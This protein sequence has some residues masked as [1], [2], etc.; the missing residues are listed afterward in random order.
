LSA[1][2][3][4]VGGGSVPR[5]YLRPLKHSHILYTK[6]VEGKSQ[7]SK[8]T[9]DH[10]PGWVLTQASDADRAWLQSVG[11]FAEAVEAS[12]LDKLPAEQQLVA[13]TILERQGKPVPVEAQADIAALAERF[14]QANAGMWMAARAIAEH[15]AHD[16]AL[17]DEAAPAASGVVV[18][19]VSQ[20]DQA[21]VFRAEPSLLGGLFRQ[22]IEK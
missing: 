15:G 17:W 21:P 3:R 14:A 13:T 22:V 18:R 1:D 5:L 2:R 12:P 11:F 7:H 16:E 4:P 8:V 19:P 10:E 20:A 9:G 6:K